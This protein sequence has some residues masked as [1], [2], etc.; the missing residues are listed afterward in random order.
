MA[1]SDSGI[2]A[3]AAS[4]VIA[5]LLP[6]TS[7]FLAKKIYA[8]ARRLILAGIPVALATDCNPGSSN[9][10][11][12]TTIAQLAVFELGMTIEETLTAMTLHPACSLG[13]GES[14]GTLEAG[15]RADVV[16]LAAPNLGHLVYHYGVPLVATVVKA[17]REVYRAGNLAAASPEAANTRAPTAA[18]R[19]RA[20]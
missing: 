14:I 3:L 10:E 8:P 15:K 17:G 20:S 19:R 6:G 7:F 18:E 2:E 1:V 16:L 12:L 9:T 4:S 13:L 11:S 5:L